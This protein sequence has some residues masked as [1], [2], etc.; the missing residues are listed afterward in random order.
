MKPY[1]Y[2]ASLAT[3]AY[4]REGTRRRISSY[5]R[6]GGNDDRVHIA[7]G[8]LKRIAEMDKP[9][10]ITHI[11][12]TIATDSRIPERDYLRKMVLMMY[13]DDEEEPSVEV[14][15][16]D[17]FGMG[18][19]MT[20]NFVSAPLQ[21]SPEDGKG[22]NCWFPMPYEKA[23][24]EILNECDSSMTVYFYID[25]EE[26]E[27]LPEGLLRFHSQWRRENPTK[28]MHSENMPNREFLFG[29][30][31]TDGAENYV[32]L[33][34]EGRGHYVG[35]NLNIHNLRDTSKWDWPGEGDD[36]IF[37]DGEKWPPSL[38]G[39]GTE[40]YF[41][42]AWCPTQQ[43]SAPYHGIISPGKDNWKGK[44][45]YYRYH[46]QDPIMFRKSIRVTIEHGHNNGRSDDWS[47]TAYWYQT[48]PHLSF[49]K[50]PPM[51][52]RLPIYEEEL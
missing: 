40:D 47:S 3:I 4:A 22:F 37:I 32:I 24:I 48:E 42:S 13:W 8:E 2:P 49:P 15:I 20:R 10:M 25:Y 44:I 12:M 36:M 26:Y 6:R 46:I 51:K 35:C 41:N 27:K 28:G 19:G 23:R 34:A 30:Y 45:T 7:S 1:L 29:G 38:H 16:G 31:N 11:W 18:H 5:D 33:E 43:Y 39:T 9:G 21:M 50:L 52:Q 14:P 17:F